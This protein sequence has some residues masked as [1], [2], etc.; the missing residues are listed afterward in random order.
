MELFVVEYMMLIAAYP[1][2]FVSQNN[3]KDLIQIAAIFVYVQELEEIAV[4]VDLFAVHL[5][6][7]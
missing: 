7:C 6:H 3:S 2:G 4:A 5:N 1:F